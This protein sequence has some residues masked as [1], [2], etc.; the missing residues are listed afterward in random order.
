M[1]KFRWRFYFL[2]KF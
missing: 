1:M 2:Y